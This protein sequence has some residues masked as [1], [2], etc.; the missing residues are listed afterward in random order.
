MEL[1]CRTCVQTVEVEDRLKYALEKVSE[2]VETKEHVLILKK[3][4]GE[5]LLALNIE[6]KEADVLTLLLAPRGLPDRGVLDHL[7]DSASKGSGHVVGIQLML[8]GERSQD[9]PTLTPVLIVRKDGAVIE[10]AVPASL[11]HAA[12]WSLALDLPFELDEDLI[13]LLQSTVAIIP[14][15]APGGFEELLAGMDEIDAL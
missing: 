11:A 6:K 9:H 15:S 2:D 1:L 8:Y 13:A 5:D 14:G 10:Q 12:A 7:R 4:D 3:A